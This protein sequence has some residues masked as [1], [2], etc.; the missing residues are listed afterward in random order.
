MVELTVSADILKEVEDAVGKHQPEFVVA[1]SNDHIKL[2]GPFVVSA[3]TGHYDSFEVKAGVFPGFPW[4]E[5]VVF[6]TGGRIPKEAD[7]HVFPKHGVCCLGVW[8][9]WLLVAP[10]QTFEAFLT[11]VMHDY[12]VSQ[13]IRAGS[14]FRGNAAGQL[15]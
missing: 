7:R 6:E 8:E 2:E 12:F 3:P 11:G 10:D 4:V 14:L 15:L 5:P 13:Y 1:A 9:E